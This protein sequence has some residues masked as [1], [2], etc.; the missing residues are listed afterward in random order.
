M[1]LIRAAD[2]PAMSI[3]QDTTAYRAGFAYFDDNITLLTAMLEQIVRRTRHLPSVRLLSLGVGYRLVVKGLAAAFEGRLDRH[4]IVE[5]SADI[6][7]LFSQDSDLPRNVELVHDY[8]ESFHTEARFD[9]IEMGFVLEHVEDPALILRRFKSFLAPEGR[10]MIAVPNAHS[11]HRL[12]GYQAGVLD[13]LHALSD[14]DRM[15]GHRRYFSPEQ[16][17]A[18]IADCG[19]EVIGRAGLMLKPF[20]SA[21][22]TSLGLN[23]PTKIAI[24]EV[25][26]GLPDICN[27]LFFEVGLCR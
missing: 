7:D 13:D 20:T 23:E 15:L 3:Q 18:L 19:L 5:G 12:I 4:V 8:F 1:R 14:A 26:F 16:L 27:G 25:G 21:Q 9:L 24:T 17:Y 2:A 10:M 22:L 6:I 11:L